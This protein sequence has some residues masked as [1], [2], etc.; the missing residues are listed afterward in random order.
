MF[1]FKTILDPRVLLKEV[2]YVSKFNLTK[3][4]GS[5][6]RLLKELILFRS[7]TSLLIANVTI[8]IVHVAFLSTFFYNTLKVNIYNIMCFSIFLS[9][10]IQTSLAQYTF[11]FLRNQQMQYIHLSHYVVPK[12]K[13]TMSISMDLEFST[14]N[15]NQEF[16]KSSQESVFY[17]SSPFF[18]SASFFQDARLSA[19]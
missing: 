11:G 17:S 4:F 7:Y 8:E 5:D 14:K 15:S 18:S 1:I 9:T 10:I 6:M 12:I 2:S 19:H 16:Q 13:P 3:H